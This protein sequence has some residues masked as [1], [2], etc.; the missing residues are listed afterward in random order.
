[1]ND[2]PPAATNPRIAPSF[3]GWLCPMSASGRAGRSF[4]RVPRAGACIAVAW[5]M[6]RFRLL[7]LVSI[8]L[9]LCLGHWLGARPYRR[10]LQVHDK[11]VARLAAEHHRAPRARS[12]R[13]AG[14]AREF[15][16]DSARVT[17]RVASSS[18][19]PFEYT[20]NYLLVGLDRR[21][22]GG[23]AGLADTILVAVFDEPSNALGLVSIPRDLW[24]DIP[25]HDPDR[26]NTVMNVARRFGE[27]PLPCSAASS[28]HAGTAGRAQLGDRHRRARARRGRAGRRHGRRALPARRPLPRSARFPRAIASWTWRRAL[29]AWTA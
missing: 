28:K 20:D 10:P 17:R 23:G 7:A 6:T 9:A 3:S 21:P 29:R 13:S 26:I 12:E 2:A 24:V 27:D 15:D 25:G 19:P 8:L 16:R 4:L 1:M 22:F 11:P 14:G 18:T 5:A